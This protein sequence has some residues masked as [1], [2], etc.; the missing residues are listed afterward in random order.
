M[1]KSSVLHQPICR[2]GFLAGLGGAA[3]WAA[4]QP[5]HAQARLGEDGLYHMDWY[6]ESFLELS[7][8]LAGAAARGKRFAV[9]W[10]LRGCPLCRRMHEVHLADPAI[11]AYVRDNFDIVHL[12]ILGS[13][14]VTDFD[15]SRLPEKAFAERYGVRGT[16]TLQFFPEAAEGLAARPPGKR[17]VARLAAL[18]DPPAFL[19]MFRYVR[20]KGYET[21]TFEAWL[22]RQA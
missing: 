2:R 16:P 1:V 17:E 11:A 12:N 3:A 6:L 13:R 5:V 7:E 14:E 21:G 22:R 20:A 8:D 18:P 19:T 15:G 10:G 4:V 9:L